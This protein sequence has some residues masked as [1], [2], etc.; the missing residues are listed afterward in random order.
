MTQ[1]TVA[2]LPG[3][4]AA[5]AAI[6]ELTR[7]DP[8]GADNQKLFRTTQLQRVFADTSCFCGLW[9]LWLLRAHRPAHDE[10]FSLCVCLSRAH[11]ECQ[12]SSSLLSAVSCH[13]AGQ[14]QNRPARPPDDAKLING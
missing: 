1:P 3:A 12:G 5:A 8:A 4:E 7:D 6:R 10:L 9:R 13:Q 14:T 11:G 2:S